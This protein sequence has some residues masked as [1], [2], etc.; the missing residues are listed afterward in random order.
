MS[1]NPDS[2]YD[3]IEDALEAGIQ[4]HYYRANANFQRSN[5]KRLNT[6]HLICGRALNA[7]LLFLLIV[8]YIIFVLMNVAQQFNPFTVTLFYYSLW[9]ATLALFS[10]IFSIV[11]IKRESWFR[12]AYISVEISY[13][14]NITI[15]WIFW[16]ILWP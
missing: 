2:A 4:K 5:F 1:V 12:A 3:R 11:A 13:A 6:N 7:I 14:A 15:F 9:G 16:L 8:M 10:M